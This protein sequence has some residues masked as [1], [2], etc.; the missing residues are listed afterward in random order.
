MTARQV[1]VETKGRGGRRTLSLPS[2]PAAVK[3]VVA[4]PVFEK[5]VPASRQPARVE[6]PVSVLPGAAALAQTEPK[7]AKQKTVK[8]LKKAPI[9][10]APVSSSLPPEYRGKP[11]EIGK[12]ISGET[13]EVVAKILAEVE[14]G[15]WRTVGLRLLVAVSR[16][17]PGYR[18]GMVALAIQNAGFP[19]QASKL[20][21]TIFKMNTARF[22]EAAS[23]SLSLVE[24]SLAERDAE[25]AREAAQAAAAGEA[26]ANG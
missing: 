21:E 17:A 19:L 26:S 9:D 2:K 11:K 22:G 25:K 7:P 18:I 4:A 13:R 10:G 15:D 14:G 23:T 6:K 12:P 5:P 16:H 20:R 1:I 24:A 8:N 3:P